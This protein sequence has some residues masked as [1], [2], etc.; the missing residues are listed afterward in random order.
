MVPSLGFLETYFPLTGCAD[1]I[2]SQLHSAA[3][4]YCDGTTFRD[5]AWARKLVASSGGKV[6]PYILHYLALTLQYGAHDMAVSV[7]QTATLLDYAP[8]IL[9]M[10]NL[11]YRVREN[12]PLSKRAAVPPVFLIS[13]NKFDALV[14]TG[15][16][17][18]ALALKAMIMASQGHEEE[19]GKWYL[20]A[21]RVGMKLYPGTYTTPPTRPVRAPRWPRWLHEAECHVQAGRA[22]LGVGKVEEAK[23]AFAFGAFELDDAA[24]LTEYAKLLPDDVPEKREFLVRAAISGYPPASVEIGKNELLLAAQERLTEEERSWHRLVGREWVAVGQGTV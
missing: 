10:T 3:Q 11:Y 19:S 1:L 5:V 7:L 16:N 22:L 20:K 9:E 6:T 17:P 2:P 4:L 13:L 23:A 15:Q 14:S 21:R 12:R 8:S 18:D 24:G